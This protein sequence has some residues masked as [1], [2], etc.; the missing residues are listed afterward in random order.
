M[1]LRHDANP[2]VLAKIDQSEYS[3]AMPPIPTQEQTV[4]LH[5]NEGHKTID[6]IVNN[7]ANHEGILQQSERSRLKW[8]VERFD[9][10]FRLK[11]L[12]KMKRIS[13]SKRE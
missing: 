4:F 1:I 12:I 2:K 7:K 11:A 6:A 5:S 9:D 8:D 13:I 10:K 3:F